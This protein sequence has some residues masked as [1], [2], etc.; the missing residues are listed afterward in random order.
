MMEKIDG[1]KYRAK[2]VSCYP[3]DSDG[4]GHFQLAAT[5]GSIAA[6]LP[7]QGT[8]FNFRWTDVTAI[9]HVYE[10]E[11]TGV[12]TTTAFAVGQILFSC[13][14]RRNWTGP[15][16]GGTLLTLTGNLVK[17]Q[18]STLV[19]SPA[20]IRVATTTGLGIGAGTGDS[21]DIGQINTHSSAGPFGATPI[22]GSVYLPTTLLFKADVGSGHSPL[23]LSANEGFSIRAVVPATGVWTAGIRVKWAE[24]TVD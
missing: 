7:A 5:T 15:T 4:R 1:Y 24:R 22:I 6:G 14:V 10:I 21:L 9:A 20:E 16:S 18:T 2:R 17:L 19:S 11:L 12:F 3:H 13:L 8:V 23:V